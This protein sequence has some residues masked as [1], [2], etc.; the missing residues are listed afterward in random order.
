MPED[1]VAQRHG[2]GGKG[3]REGMRNDIY[4]G[5]EQ[6]LEIRLSA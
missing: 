2:Q 1:E 5:T 4:I 6:R 3:N